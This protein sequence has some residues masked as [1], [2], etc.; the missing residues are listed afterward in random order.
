MTWINENPAQAGVYA[1][2]MELGLAAA[3]V[4][5]SMPG[6]NIRH[7]PVASIKKELNDF[8]KVLYD[9]DPKTIGE[10]IPDEGLYYEIR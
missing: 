5:K 6:N 1:E 2:E 8:F 9:F 10:A 7:E 3:I 4:E